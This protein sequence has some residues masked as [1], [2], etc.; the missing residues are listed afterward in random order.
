MERDI[1]PIPHDDWPSSRISK[2]MPAK[3]SSPSTP[4]AIAAS[5]SPY[6]RDKE[7]AMSMLTAYL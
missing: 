6:V 7:K 3:A 4:R 1:R 5:K 2:N